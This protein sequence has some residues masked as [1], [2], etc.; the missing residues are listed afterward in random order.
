MPAPHKLGLQLHQALR[1]KADHLA[2]ECRIRALLQKRAKGDL[3]IGYR[4]D[5]QVKVACGNST[6]PKIHHGGRRPVS[7]RQ[8]RGG[9]YG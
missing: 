5:P 3:V 6:L 9:R 2:Q 1:C 7:L 8:T 4:G